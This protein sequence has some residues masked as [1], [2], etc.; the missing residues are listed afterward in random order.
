MMVFKCRG[1]L[2]PLN[3]G[4]IRVLFNHLIVNKLMFYTCTNVWVNKL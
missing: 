1:E 3:D 2:V 4:A